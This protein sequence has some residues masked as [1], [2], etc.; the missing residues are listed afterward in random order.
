[1]E[2]ITPRLT[3]KPVIETDI[4][5][6]REMFTCPVTTR[7]LPEGKPYSA[8]QIDKYLRQRI[9]HWQK[10]FGTFTVFEQKSGKRI[11]YSGVE[12]SPQ[13]EYCDIRYGIERSC[14]GKGYAVEAARAVLEFTSALGMHNRIYGAVLPDNQGSLKILQKL[15]MTPEPDIDFYGCS[16]LVYLSFATHS[17]PQQ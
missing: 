9:A 15:G 10:G 5:L 12:E 11:G 2:I 13:K 17:G 1:M 4:G 8:K 14:T 7:F 16:A 6:Y 3:L